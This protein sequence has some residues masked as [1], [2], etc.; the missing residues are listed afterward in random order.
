VFGHAIEGL[1]RLGRQLIVTL[2]WALI[3][4]ALTLAT[5]STIT[6]G[7]AQAPGG[8]SDRQAPVVGRDGGGDRRAIEGPTAR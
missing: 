5:W 4:L 7:R 1:G 6:S 2:T 3:L 8:T